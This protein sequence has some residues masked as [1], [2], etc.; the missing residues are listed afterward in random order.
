MLSVESSVGKY[1]VEVVTVMNEIVCVAKNPMPKRDPY[2]F[3]SSKL[4][5]T[6][7]VFHAACTI[8]A[9]RSIDSKHRPGLPILAFSESIRTV[10]ELDLFRGL[11][12]PR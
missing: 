9:W 7:T 6:E 11:I 10:R 12:H 5:I 4:A 2:D 8:R 3:D 1:L